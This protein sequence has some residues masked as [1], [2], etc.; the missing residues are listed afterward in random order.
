MVVELLR[1]FLRQGYQQGSW[2]LSYLN[3]TFFLHEGEGTHSLITHPNHSAMW[4][5][6]PPCRQLWHQV[7]HCPNWSDDPCT[8]AQTGMN[9]IA[10]TKSTFTTS[11]VPSVWGSS[12]NH[13]ES[14]FTSD[15]KRIPKMEG[16]LKRG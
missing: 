16:A 1:H 2:S 6:C 13:V 8:P 5:A 10:Y 12:F 4:W 15:Q 14:M 9:N 3:M 7:N 11:W